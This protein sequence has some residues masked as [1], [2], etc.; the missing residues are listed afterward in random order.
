MYSQPGKQAVADQKVARNKGLVLAQR[1]S[2]LGMLIS[3]GLTLL[4][5]AG[6]WKFFPFMGGWAD[7]FLSRFQGVFNLLNATI[8]FYGLLVVFIL[9]YL[10]LHAFKNSWIPTVL[11]GVLIALPVL[12]FA[13]IGVG[14]LSWF[15]DALGGTK[16]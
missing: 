15:F 9:Y 13:A 5:F 4:C 3:L 11:I 16:R 12:N 10:R 7:P 8:V 1:I 14:V 2:F 6:Y